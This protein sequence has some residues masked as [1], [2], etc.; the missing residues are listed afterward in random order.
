MSHTITSRDPQ[1]QSCGCNQKTYRPSELDALIAQYEK[2]IK[3]T[4]D[5]RET[6]LQQILALED[7]AHETK[8]TANK[9]EILL[10]IQEIS[11]SVDITPI[12]S[13]QIQSL[14]S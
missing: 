14:F 7:I 9:N 5:A 8:A 11:H 10:A 3:E 2:L 12:T 6:L 13:S 4:Q 1:K